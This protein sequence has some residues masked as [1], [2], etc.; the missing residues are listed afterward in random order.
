MSN[1]WL[2]PSLLFSTTMMVV[3]VVVM[4]MDSRNDCELSTMYR[5]TWFIAARLTEYLPTISARYLCTYL[6]Q[7]VT[8]WT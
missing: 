7:W 5:G 1:V 3:V 4:A 8:R 6:L 2:L